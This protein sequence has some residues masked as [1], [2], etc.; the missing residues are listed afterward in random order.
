MLQWVQT[1][2][3]AMLHATVGGCAARCMLRWV[4][5]KAAAMLLTAVEVQATEAALQHAAVV[6]GERDCAACMLQLVSA[7]DVA[8]CGAGGASGNERRRRRLRCRVLRWAQ[9]TALRHMLRWAQ[10]KEAAL[11]SAAVGVQ[12]KEASLLHAA[13]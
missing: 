3:A 1:K 11:L 12:A 5:T 4:Q 13:W 6:E 9:E 7:K 8:P 2:G 10:T